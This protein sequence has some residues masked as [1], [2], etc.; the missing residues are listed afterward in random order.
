MSGHESNNAN[1]GQSRLT[2]GLEA[3]IPLNKKHPEQGAAVFAFWP[4]KIGFMTGAANFGVAIYAAPSHWHNPEDD[5]DDYCEP[6]HWM[7][8]P[9]APNQM[10]L[11]NK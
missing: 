11:E 10:K 1:E 7:P 5:E 6:T 2:V 3:W 8:L 4:P 9:E